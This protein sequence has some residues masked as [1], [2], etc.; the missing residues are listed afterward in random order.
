MDKPSDEAIAPTILKSNH[1]AQ[2]DV[3]A[4]QFVDLD[5]QRKEMLAK[6]ARLA[7][8]AKAQPA[9]L[10]KQEAFE[11][12]KRD[13]FEQGYQ[14]GFEQ[15]QAAGLQAATAENHQKLLDLEQRLE[16]LIAFLSSPNAQLA[17]QV[18][19]QT[20]E[21]AVQLAEG[22]IT[23]SAPKDTDHLVSLIKQAMQ[24]LN[25]DPEPEEP[26]MT[27]WLHPDDLAAVAPVLKAFRDDL[28]L[29]ADGQ[30]AVGNFKLH[31]KFSEVSY[32]WRKEMADYLTK[33]REQWLAADATTDAL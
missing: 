10:I 5:Q 7:A 31:H 26:S 4:W 22:F 8:E 24:R 25:P 19:Q 1:L 23:D 6:Q 20:V 16:P 27:L 14:E 17:D 18:F 15:G 29:V 21:L 30:L 33:A 9:K 28:K 12:A 2:H 32:D 13:G 11:Q 3:Q